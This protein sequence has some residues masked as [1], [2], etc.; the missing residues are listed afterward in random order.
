LCFATILLLI[1]AGSVLALWQFHAYNRHVQKL[2]RIDR[3]VMAVLRVNNVVLA[4]QGMLQNAAVER[5]AGKFVN[6]IRPFKDGL[7]RDLDA[8]RQALRDSPG[9][10]QEHAVTMAVLGYF[11]ST[12]P[13]QIDVALAMAEA[14]DWV[15]LHLRL[16]NQVRDMSRI[17]ASLVQDVDTEAT[18]ERE[19]SLEA[20]E[21]A[22]ERAFV[23]LL[24]CG[25]CTVIVAGALALTATRYRPAA[26]AA[27]G[28][29]ARFGRR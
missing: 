24:V 21:G 6:A 15:A 16:D 25:I 13:K 20:I 10:S 28:Q 26:E 22:R 27:R 4:Y 1:V 9:A 8:A 12:V 23:I 14:G 2:D 19:Q 18:R 3:Q 17:V 5:D 11:R 29:C 7:S